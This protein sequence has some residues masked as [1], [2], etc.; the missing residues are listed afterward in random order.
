MVPW[1]LRSVQAFIRRNDITAD[2][3]ACHAPELHGFIRDLLILAAQEFV[4]GNS[5][6]QVQHLARELVERRHA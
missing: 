2:D 5:D 4:Q 1:D 3:F 6:G